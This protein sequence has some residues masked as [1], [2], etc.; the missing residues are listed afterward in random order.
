MLH[1]LLTVPIGLSQHVVG[2][3]VTLLASSLTYYSYRLLLPGAATPPTIEAFQPLAIPGLSDLP[4][5]G[6]A[7][8][9]QTPMTY[10]ALAL[11]PVAAYV[12]YRTPMGLAL[13]MVGENPHAAEAQGI[14]VHAVRMTA[15][16]VGSALMAIGGAFLTLAAFNSFF[17]TMVQGRGWVCIALVVFASW[18]PGKALFGALLYGLFDAYQLRLQHAV[19][20]E[21]PLPALPDDTLPPEHPRPHPD[22]APRRLPAGPHAALSPGRAGLTATAHGLPAPPNT[23]LLAEARESRD[24]RASRVRSRRDMRETLLSRSGIRRS[25]G[26][27]SPRFGGGPPVSPAARMLVPGDRVHRDALRRAASPGSHPLGVTGDQHRLARGWR[28]GTRSRSRR[29]CRSRSPSTP[30]RRGTPG[31]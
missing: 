19:A 7:L 11:I 13:R 30:A 16:V 27:R 9:S 4:L 12:L 1:A 15:V 26:G 24:L 28:A 2:L 3:G 14:S 8:F 21:I 18:R 20:K 23:G 17:F 10:L 31:R 22:V 25:R 29:A 6:E 5:V